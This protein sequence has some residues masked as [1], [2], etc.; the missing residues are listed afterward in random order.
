[1]LANLLHNS[2]AAGAAT[3]RVQVSGDARTAVL[4]IADDGGRE[5]GPVVGSAFDRFVRGDN[6]RTPGT[7]GAGLGLAIVRAVVAA[8][9][10]SV[11]ARNGTPLGGAVVTARFPPH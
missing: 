4:E 7:S 9:S 5:S 8:H 6:A 11:E 10:G 1:V 3:V 2:A